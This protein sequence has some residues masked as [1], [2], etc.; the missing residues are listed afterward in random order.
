VLVLTARDTWQDKV[1]GIDAGAD[2]YLAKPFE[3]PE[4]LA[5]LRAIIRRRHGI[6]TT[7]LKFGRLEVD[8]RHA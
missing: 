4:M 1:E 8:T 7:R 2:D 6:A 3:M 5:R